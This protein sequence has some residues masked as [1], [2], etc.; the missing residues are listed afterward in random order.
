MRSLIG[1]MRAGAGPVRLEASLAVR[2]TTDV[3]AARELLFRVLALASPLGWGLA[4]H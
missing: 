4:R 2:P 3:L 1:R